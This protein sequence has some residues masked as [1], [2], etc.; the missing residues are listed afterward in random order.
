MQNTSND[1]KHR[2]MYKLIL[3]SI[4]IFEWDFCFKLNLKVNNV[5]EMTKREQANL[6]ENKINYFFN[7][8]K[9]TTYYRIIEFLSCLSLVQSVA[10]R[11]ISAEITCLRADLLTLGSFIPMKGC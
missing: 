11:R 8:I 5:T 7:S 1:T 2:Y 10:P 3:H 6:H 4:L 9:L